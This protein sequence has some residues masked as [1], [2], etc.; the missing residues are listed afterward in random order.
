MSTR[1]CLLSLKTDRSYVFI[2]IFGLIGVRFNY[3]HVASDYSMS[4]LSSALYFPI[5]FVSS[6]VPSTAS[7][8]TS[9]DGSDAGSISPTSPQGDDGSTGNASPP[10]GSPEPSARA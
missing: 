6:L 8:N 1:V 5:A 2:H 7:E 10:P 3:D 9:V 4:N